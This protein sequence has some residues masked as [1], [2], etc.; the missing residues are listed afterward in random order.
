MFSELSQCEEGGVA[1][2]RARVLDALTDVLQPAGQVLGAHAL[3]AALGRHGQRQEGRLALVLVAADQQLL[4]VLQL[5][6]ESGDIGQDT[7]TGATIRRHWSRV[8]KKPAE[9]VFVP[10]SGL[11]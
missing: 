7:D 2:H 11:N 4:N 1:D 5:R 3:R 10:A 8:G 6:G 9:I